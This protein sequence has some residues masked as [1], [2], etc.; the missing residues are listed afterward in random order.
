M[1]GFKATNQEL[2]FN[3]DEIVLFQRMQLVSDEIECISDST[4]K[5]PK[6]MKI[7]FLREYIKL[8]TS[9]KR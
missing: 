3:D 2:Q 9:T 8:R 7:L 6:E 1:L 4:N 5:E